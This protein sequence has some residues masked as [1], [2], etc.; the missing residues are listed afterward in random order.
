MTVAKMM[1]EIYQAMGIL[2]RPNV[3]MQDGRH[4]TGDAGCTPQ[5]LSLI[6]I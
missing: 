3:M 4:L 6:H 2:S 5:Q 1:G